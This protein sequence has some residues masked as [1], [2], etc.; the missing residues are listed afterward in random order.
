ML[1]LTVMF[2][3]ARLA[4]NRDTD[5]IGAAILM[6]MKRISLFSQLFIGHTVG[7]MP[8]GIDAV[9]RCRFPSQHRR[10]EGD[11]H[12]IDLRL[13]D[14]R[15]AVDVLRR[16]A[17][18]R[19]ATTPSSGTGSCPSVRAVA[20]RY[21]ALPPTRCGRPRHQAAEI[22]LRGR[23]KVSRSFPDDLVEMLNSVSVLFGCF[24][25]SLWLLS[26]FSPQLWCNDRTTLV[27]VI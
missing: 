13:C 18:L 23:R 7:S 14:A 5:S 27:F 9:R 12:G 11:R 22:R 8:F 4:P 15:D 17:R 16:P 25:T 26:C 21:G 20:R 19:E 10:R 6:L 3:A 24:L 1:M 2:L